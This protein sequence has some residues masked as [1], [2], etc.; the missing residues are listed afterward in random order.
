[1]IYN[2]GELLFIVYPFR[3]LLEIVDLGVT[4]DNKLKFNTH[5]GEVI[6]KAKQRIYQLFKSFTS[7]NVS[8][9][10][11]AYKTYVLPI[12]DYCLSVWTPDSLL[13]IDKLEAVQIIYTKRL[14]A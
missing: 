2:V 1:M 9:F 11:F 3:V 6:F 7:R 12:L 13:E 14:R 8:L 4:I 5:I 10:I